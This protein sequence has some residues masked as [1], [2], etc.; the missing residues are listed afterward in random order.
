MTVADDPVGTSVNCQLGIICCRALL[1]RLER[2]LSRCRTSAFR[3]I[4]GPLRVVHAHPLAGA[5]RRLHDLHRPF[6]PRWPVWVGQWPFV[7]ERRKSLTGPRADR[8]HCFPICSKAAAQDGGL[9]VGEIRCEWPPR[10]GRAS[11]AIVAQTG[12]DPQNG[13]PVWPQ[14][15]RLLPCRSR[16][17][18]TPR[19]RWAR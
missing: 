1:P 9:P 19:W 7:S 15:R 12:S 10:L 16:I 2:P 18:I 14:P 11:Q 5:E 17:A 6:T 3:K 4:E 8:R 13:H